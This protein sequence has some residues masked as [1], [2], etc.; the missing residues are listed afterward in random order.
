ME[1]LADALKSAER[2]NMLIDWDVPI[3][4]DDGLVLRADVYRPLQDGPFPVIASYGP[5]AKGLTFAAG[6]PRQ[7][8]RLNARYPKDL[9]GSTGKYA[10]WELVDPEHW[11]AFGYAVVRID[12]RGAGRSPGFIDVWSKREAQDYYDCIE[13]IAAQDWSNGKVGLA[14]I[15]YYAKNQWQVAE[16]NPPHLAA[17]CPW[18]G[19][20]DYFRD[21]THHGGI[22]NAFLPDWYQ[23][24]STIQYGLG[25]RGFK[26]P[27]SGLWACGDEDLTDDELYANRCDLAKQII[28]HPFDD[29]WHFAHSSQPEKIK[30]PTLSAANWGGLGNHQRGNLYAWTATGSDKKWLEVHNGTHWSGFYTEY[31]RTLQKRFFDYFLKG[32]GDWQQQPLVFLNIRQVDGTVKLRA[33]NEWPLAR[34]EWLRKYLNPSNKSIND[35]APQNSESFTYSA[36]GEGI[37]FYAAPLAQST[38][39]TG[40]VSA[41]IWISSSTS[42]ADLFLILRA[43]SEEGKE[44]LFEGANDPKTPLSQ[45]WLR[46]SHRGIDGTQSKPWAPYHPHKRAEP[47]VPGQ[48]YEL[49]IEIWA[50]CLALPAGYR[51]A[52]TVKGCDFDHG[53][54]PVEMGGRIMKGSGPF[55]H[56]HPE[57]RPAAIF[58]NQVTIYAGGQHPSSILLPVVPA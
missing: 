23:R 31:G 19:A 35:S 38:E 26:N 43:F 21:M 11:T 28:E 32:E 8:E 29:D 54:E 39:I 36:M 7:W 46:A 50:T 34:T 45:G 13:W 4:M 40:P 14:G 53:L 48:I 37:T 22:H 30:V 10:A 3:T 17:I 2:E 58:D 49:E 1:P 25:S 41:K 56:D 18:E 5:Y 6:Y 24:M 52:L 55:R 16:L 20:N 9:E 15:S 33:E 57:D 27:E 12:S 51:L 47:L 42:D 44:I